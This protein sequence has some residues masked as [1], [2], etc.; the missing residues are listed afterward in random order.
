MTDA[1]AT[2]LPF[3]SIKNIQETAQVKVRA[4]HVVGGA[5]LLALWWDFVAVKG[6]GTLGLP[7]LACSLTL[8][9]NL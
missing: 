1:G 9:I 8:P 7:Y 5:S 6:I 4:V 2:A 3:L